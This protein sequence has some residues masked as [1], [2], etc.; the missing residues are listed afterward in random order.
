[1]ERRLLEPGRAEEVQHLVAEPR[2][3]MEDREALDLA[4]ATA[5]LL[6]D[7]AAHRLLRRLALFEDARGHL[8]QRLADR[9]AILAHEHQPPLVVDEDSGHGAAVPHPLAQRPGPA[10]L[11][12]LLQLR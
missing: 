11:P 2:R 6:L 4:R 12:E 3:R 7:L 9:V 8:P 1:M 5:D 10:P